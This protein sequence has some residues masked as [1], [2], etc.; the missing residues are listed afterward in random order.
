[1]NKLFSS[2]ICISC[3]LSIAYKV[4][5]I[6]YKLPSNN[7]RIIGEISYHTVAK[8][9]HFQQLAQQ[10]NVGFLALMAANPGIDPLLPDVGTQLTIPTKLI[11]PFGKHEGI[12]INLAELRL[13]YFDKAKKTVNV[14]PVGIGKL[15]KATPKLLSKIT[16]KRTNPN[17][18]PTT[19]KRKE[20]FATH[21][22]EL[23]R[24][25]KAGPDNPLGDFAMRIGQSEYL[26]HGTNQR[27]G[28]GMRAS[29]GC[30]RMNPEDIEWLFQRANSG[31]KVKIVDHPI[32]MTYEPPNRRVIEVHAPLTVTADETPSLYPLSSGIKRFIG[33]EPEDLALIEQLIANP[34]GIPVEIE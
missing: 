19:S 18:Y 1:M 30:I 5:A 31:T 3:L 23:P 27:F 34:H 7:S 11:L 4:S 12:V 29:S 10:Y 22:V 26:I 20:H 6:E 33:N 15:G 9:E 32:K 21:G 2:I 16:E 14:F 28:I 24:M 25:V 17:W 13:Y 8:G